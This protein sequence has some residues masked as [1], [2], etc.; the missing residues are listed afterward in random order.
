M[1]FIKHT[2][3]LSALSSWTYIWRPDDLCGPCITMFVLD[4]DA[5]V[6]RF[7]AARLVDEA[8]VGQA[9]RQ[10]LEEQLSAFAA[11]DLDDVGLHRFVLVISQADGHVDPGNRKLVG[12]RVPLC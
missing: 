8:D 6:G 11:P 9:C 3:M 12:L 4:P 1:F 10:R 2:S 5:P 7:P